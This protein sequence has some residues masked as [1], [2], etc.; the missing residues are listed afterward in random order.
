MSDSA[1]PGPSIRVVRSDEFSALRR[2]EFEAAR[3]FESVGI[4]PFT[5]DEDEN[6]FEQAELV[7]VVGDPP[8]GFA[9]VE[10]VDGNH[11]SGKWRCTRTTVAR[12]SEEP[13]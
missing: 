4:G 13:W 10:L 11:L 12:A 5:N 8:V 6:H 3:M 7:V 9:C 1:Q 2:I